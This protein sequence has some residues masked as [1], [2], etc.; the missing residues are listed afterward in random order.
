MRRWQRQWKR[1]GLESVKVPN[2]VRNVRV[3]SPLTLR[4]RPTGLAARVRGQKRVNLLLEHALLDSGQELFG[5]SERQA[6]VLD[7]LGVFRQGETSVTVS[8][9]PS[10]VHM[11]S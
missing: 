7:A 1:R 9:R 2:N 8:S 3:W 10:S 11:T 5:F 4:A 6:Q